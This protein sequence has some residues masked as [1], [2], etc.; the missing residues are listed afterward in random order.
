MKRIL[1]LAV[2]GLMAGAASLS[3]QAPQGGANPPQMPPI[4]NPEEK[5]AQMTEKFSLTEE[6][7]TALLEL[8]KQFDGKLEFRPEGMGER[9]DPRKMS[10]EEREAFFNQMMDQMA[11]MQE[12]MQEMQKAQ[13]EYDKA[14]KLILTKD[15][16][17]EYRKEQRKREQ[18][19]QRMQQQSGMGGMQGGFPGGGFPGGGFGGPGGGFG[20]PGGF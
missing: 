13:K 15:Q 3:A 9:K 7:Q 16:F 14:L 11:E 4:L 5:T 10:D 20:G 1:L 12:R 2:A 6:Q 17:K 8:N 18:E 19:M